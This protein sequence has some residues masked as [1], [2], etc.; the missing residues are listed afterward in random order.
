[1]SL[2]IIVRRI[3]YLFTSFE[4]LKSSHVISLSAPISDRFSSKLTSNSNS[5]YYIFTRM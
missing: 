4:Y 2:Y 1:M 5:C 3:K